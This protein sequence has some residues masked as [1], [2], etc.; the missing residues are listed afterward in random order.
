MRHV[1][2]VGSHG[3]ERL[4]RWACFGVCFVVV[5][6][7]VA[8]G[9]GRAEAATLSFAPASPFAAGADPLSVTSGDF[10]RDGDLDLATANFFSDDVS[11]LLNTGNGTYAAATTFPAGT[12]PLVGDQRRL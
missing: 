10:D 7:V 5:I 6:A 2:R 11:V 9:A 12:N 8:L 3:H 4:D 1:S